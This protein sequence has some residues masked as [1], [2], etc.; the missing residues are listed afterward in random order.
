MCLGE[1]LIVFFDMRILFILLILTIVVLV[2]E[3]GHYVVARALGCRV[4]KIQIFS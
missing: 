4:S 3:I 2:H 1:M